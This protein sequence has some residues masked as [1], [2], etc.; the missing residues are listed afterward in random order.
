MILETKNL[1]IGYRKQALI[2]N[3][4]LHLKQGE[5]TCLLGPNGIG[6]STLLHTLTG[7]IPAVSGE[8][9]IQGQAINKLTPR[10]LATCIGMVLSQKL[11]PVNLTVFEI[12]ALG[13]TPY[14]NWLGHLTKQDQMAI[15][16]AMELVKVEDFSS[17]FIGELSDGERQRV[18]IAKALAQDT[19]LLVLDEPTAHLDVNNRVNLLTLLKTLAKETDKAILLSTHELEMAIQ[20]A[21]SVWLITEDRNVIAG[22]AE[23]L[24]LAGMMEK[25]FKGE[26]VEFDNQTGNFKIK[27]GLNKQVS[28]HGMGTTAIWTRKALEKEGFEILDNGYCDIQ[29][30]IGQHSDNNWLI[31]ANNS[32]VELN[33][34]QELKTELRSITQYQN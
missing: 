4:N 7:V 8:A 12:V 19:P 22:S 34:I 27:Y 11:T 17:R 20:L 2:Q 33:S 15:Q 3:L 31:K 26:N 28:L 24:V 29:I 9:F 25:T 23:D 10:Q 6:K 18:M 21:D 14:T 5:L 1:S 30:H 16:V 32:E 13:R